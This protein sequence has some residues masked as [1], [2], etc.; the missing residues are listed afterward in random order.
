M[1]NEKAPILT[2]E[3]IIQHLKERRNIEKE[4]EEYEKYNKLITKNAYDLISI[5]NEEFEYEYI[6]DSVHEK[7]LGY[8]KEDLIGKMI[9][10]LIHPQD[11]LRTKNFFENLNFTNGSSIELRIKRTNGTYIWIESRGNLVVEEDGQNKI[12]LISRDLTERRKIEEALIESEEKF[13]NLFEKSPNSIILLDLE[14]IVV[15]CNK[16]TERILNLPK[17]KIVNENIFTFNL[18]KGQSKPK[19]VKSKIKRI[20]KQILNEPITEPIEFKYTNNRNEIIWL[21]NLFSHVKIGGKDYIQIVSEDVTKLK[22]V[23]LIIQE[24]NKRLKMLDE[25]RGS[26]INRASHELKTPISSIYG[27]SEL[28]SI[29]YEELYSKYDFLFSPNYKEFIDLIRSGSKRLKNLAENLLNLSQLNI[30]ILKLNKERVDISQLLLECIKMLLI[31]ARKRNIQI[32]HNISGKVE[33]Y[34]DESQ[35]F[36]VFQNL[37]SNSIN[38]TPPNGEIVVNIE[39]NNKNLIISVRDTGVGLTS[40]EQKKIFTK[41]GKIERNHLDIINEGI[42]FGL[43]LSKEIIK[44][45][46]GKIWAE[47][48]GRNRGSTF[49]F[50]L[51][52]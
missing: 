49:F 18:T 23:E 15:D 9:F 5:F 21:K 37:I 43:F 42:G 19:S 20:F 39:E 10:S 26:F 36:R 40:E 8:K 7:L 31:Q 48:E 47:S 50:S 51:P 30:N 34:I 4:L 6:N 2:I 46:N 17:N 52:L 22:Q 24:E 33:L 13:R 41:F 14:G 32:K 25:L 29:M 16:I 3:G 28:I 11:Q 44:L 1:T 12:L 45:H 35:I 27:A 38:N